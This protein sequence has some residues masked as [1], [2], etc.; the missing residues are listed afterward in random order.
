VQKKKKKKKK[1]IVGAT[2][3]WWTCATCCVTSMESVLR[4]VLGFLDRESFFL[5]FF[6]FVWEVKQVMCADQFC[7]VRV[8]VASGRL[9]YH[10]T[11]K[12]ASGPKCGDCGTSLPG[13][14]HLRPKEYRGISKRQKTVNRA[15]G[16]S[17]CAGCVRDRVVRAFL[18]EERKIVKNV[19]KGKQAQ[20]KVVED[21]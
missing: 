15:Y 18:V 20:K 14:A 7:F 21:K 10:Y 19:L 5:F 1:K 3:A 12:V 13:I 4:C 11:S 8:K 6:P 17:K 16:G 2:R 9:T